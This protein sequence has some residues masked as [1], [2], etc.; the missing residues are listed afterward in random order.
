MPLL[1]VHPGNAELLLTHPPELA[2]LV[3][4][5]RGRRKSL[6]RVVLGGS[7][8]GAGGG[9]VLG[10][11]FGGSL[12]AVGMGGT[13]PEAEDVAQIGEGGGTVHCTSRVRYRERY[14]EVGV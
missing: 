8:L 6:Q 7:R 12:R 1:F 11:A 14:S 9:E 5:G 3:V 2:S 13:L 4:D 10:L